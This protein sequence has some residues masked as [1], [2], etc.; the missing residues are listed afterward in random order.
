MTD[1]LDAA[2]AERDGFQD[3]LLRSHAELDNFRRR[4]SKELADA[5]EYQSLKL[6]GDILPCL[7]NLRRAVEAAETSKNIDELTQ[8]IQ[9]VSKQFDGILAA[10][11]ATPIQSV[12][13]PFDPNCHMALTQV[14]SAD[15][16]PMTVLQEVERGYKL[17]D[18][19]VRPSS[20]IV[21]CAPTAQ[22]SGTE[23]SE[24][25]EENK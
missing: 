23:S 9:M 3:Q 24:P 18:R 10:H 16:E 4:S 5:R 12:G 11:G 14:P 15:H 21:S 19:V 25:T 20:V 8:G 2:I 7:D 13:Q 1:Q 6:V 17:K 22:D